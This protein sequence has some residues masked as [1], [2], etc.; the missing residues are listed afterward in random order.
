MK[1]KKTAELLYSQR[2]ILWAIGEKPMT[3]RQIGE[4]LGVTET[5]V[6]SNLNKLTARGLVSVVGDAP[7]TGRRAP[8]Y[9]AKT[10]HPKPDQMFAGKTART[11]PTREAVISAIRH[12]P[13]TVQEIAHET[14]LRLTQ[15]N[16]FICEIRKNH[17]N[18][19]V[20]ISSWNQL[21]G[22]GPVA[23]YSVGPGPDAPKIK[24]TKKERDAIW[25]EKNRER[26]RILHRQWKAKNEKPVVDFGPF[27][28]LLR[29][30]GATSAASKR[31]SDSRKAES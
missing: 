30:V 8:I 12:I 6:I 24:R 27:G 14:G 9:A 28:Q 13:M 31:Y 25:R 11:S 4:T 2:L 5:C 17:G 10:K 23:V 18:R 21:D 26:I 1:E 29:V 15:V 22:Y 16:G 7:T 20:R 3:R 19:V